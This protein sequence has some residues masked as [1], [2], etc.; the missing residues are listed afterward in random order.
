MPQ[1]PDLIATLTN[2]GKA[3]IFDRTKVPSIPA[4][5]AAVSPQIELVGHKDE[6]FAMNWNSNREGELAT[7]S[8][9]NTV[10][11]W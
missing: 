1:N 4:P 3:C 6:G 11:L 10:K 2:S 8:N 9:D 5:G 7:G